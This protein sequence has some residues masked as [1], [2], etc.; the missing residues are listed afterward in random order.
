MLFMEYLPSLE[1]I[2]EKRIKYIKE[3]KRRE[4]VY[5]KKHYYFYK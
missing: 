1:T 2:Q 5:I 3:M 4:F